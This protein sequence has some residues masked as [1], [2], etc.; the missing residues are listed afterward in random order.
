MRAR[1]VKPGLFENEI[2]GKEDPLL[3]LLF[4]GLWCLA[5][6]DGRLEDRPERIKVQIFPYRKGFEIEK[7]LSTLYQLGFIARYKVG[8]KRYIQV[9]EFLK[10]QKPHHTE[11]SKNFPACEDKY[12]I[13]KGDENLTVK[14][15][16]DNGEL[17]VVERSDSLIHG[18]T[19]SLI[20]GF[21]EKNNKKRQLAAS[22]Y[23]KSEESASGF[24]I[25]WNLYPKRPGANK[26]QAF[27]QWEA[28]LKAGAT[29]EEMQQGA[30]RYRRYCQ[31]MNVE[32][33]YVKQAATFLGPHKH[34]LLD[35]KPT[36]KN[37]FVDR[38]TGRNQGGDDDGTIIDV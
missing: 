21:T 1:N 35:W 24:N 25:F 10:H 30:D 12:L 3:T 15:T 31:A 5:D 19:D 37:S 9:I 4:Q 34:Y 18:F 20:H 8:D 27:M 36:R 26:S 6:R 14:S 29:M 38:L 33:Q 11:K 28:R 23:G 17:T 7:L 13:S 2:L 16:L 22:H 32:P